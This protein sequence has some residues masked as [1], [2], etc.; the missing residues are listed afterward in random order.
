MQLR[1]TLNILASKAATL[2]NKNTLTTIEKQGGEVLR[3]GGGRKSEY[4]KPAVSYSTL[5]I[6][7]VFLFR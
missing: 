4:D 5:G 6:I 1:T 3:S 2:P 7:G